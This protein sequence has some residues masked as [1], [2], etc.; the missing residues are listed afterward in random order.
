MGSSVDRPGCLPGRQRSL[1]QTQGVVL[2]AERLRQL[3]QPL[4][5]GEKEVMV[6]C[7]RKIKEL[8]LGGAQHW[9]SSNPSRCGSGWGWGGAG[10]RNLA[11]AGREGGGGGRAWGEGGF[12]VNQAVWGG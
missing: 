1:G 2:Q 10:G 7:T 4:W 6:F 11:L 12:L 8:K 5:A 3:T 9:L